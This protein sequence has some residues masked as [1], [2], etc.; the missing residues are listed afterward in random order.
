MTQPTEFNT[1]LRPYQPQWEDHRWYLVVMQGPGDIQAYHAAYHEGGCWQT[2][3]GTDLTDD[4]WELVA[5]SDE[6]PLLGLVPEKG[7]KPNT[8]PFDLTGLRSL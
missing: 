2:A 3:C 4:G 5:I 1:T 7:A 8:R 6:L